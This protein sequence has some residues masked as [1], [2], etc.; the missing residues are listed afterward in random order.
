MSDRAMASDA[1]V[2]SSQAHHPVTAEVIGL[3]RTHGASQYG[4]EAVTQL[5][6]GLQ[7]A[8]LAEKQGAAPELICAALLH[9]AGHLLH[10]LP[11]DAPEQGID[12]RHEVLGQQ[13]LERW[14]P[15]SVSE[16]VRMHV[17]AKR[18]LC[19]VD[20]AYLGILSEPSVR[21]L[22]LQGGPM[23]QSEVQAFE[24]TEYCP[25][26]V[27]LRR[28]DDQAKDPT[29]ETPPIEHFAKYLDRVLEGC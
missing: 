14:F 1:C 15:K 25:H 13:W 8:W 29:L 9:D 2:R 11:D 17:D 21:S 4:S 12:D 16:P 19:A 24:E 27:A 23:N 22:M 6:H 3:F 20:P 7:A 5:Q 28:W 10:D 26:A 18:Y